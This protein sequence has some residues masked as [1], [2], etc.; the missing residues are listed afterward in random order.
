LALNLLM[1]WRSLA[2][3][4]LMLDALWCWQPENLLLND[5]SCLTNK[6]PRNQLWGSL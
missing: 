4:L 5:R 2:Q 6:L 3:K 1:L